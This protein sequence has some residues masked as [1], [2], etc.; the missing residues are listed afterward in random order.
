MTSS[1]SFPKPHFRLALELGHNGGES[2]C[3]DRQ[4]AEDKTCSFVATSHVPD[5][6]K[7]PNIWGSPLTHAW[8]WCP[9][10]DFADVAAGLPEI[11][12]V[13]DALHYQTRDIIIK[14]HFL[15]RLDIFF[16]DNIKKQLGHDRYLQDL[17]Q[18][19]WDREWEAGSGSTV[20]FRFKYMQTAPE[21]EL[22]RNWVEV[23]ARVMEIALAGPDE[24]KRCLEAIFRIQYEANQGDVAW[25]QLMK[26]VLKLG[27]RIPDWRNQLARY[28]QGEIIADVHE[29]GL[30][31]K[32]MGSFYSQPPA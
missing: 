20:W 21:Y 25:E 2:F 15:T 5:T 6:M 13:L 7:N 26:H 32:R 23:I 29:N 30:L 18:K 3:Y 31:R 4:R 9:E 24:Y 1:H 12:A 28:E 11:E 22:L 16:E 17:E 14:E 8:C 27:H 10:F 19:W